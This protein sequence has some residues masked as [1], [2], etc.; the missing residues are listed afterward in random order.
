V[1]EQWQLKGD[2]FDVCKCTIPCPCTFAQ[3][4]SEGDC[5]GILAWH[6]NE[7]HYGDVSL[8]GLNIIGV[9]SF[10]GNIWDEETKATMGM[11]MDERADDA[12]REA[13]QIIFSGQA[14][15][16]PGEFAQS[17]GEVRGMEFA[18]I[19]FE[20][21][22]DLA[23]WRAEIPGKVE[24]RAEALTGPTTPEGARVQTHNPPGAEVGP[25][26]VATWGVATASKADAMGWSFDW[27]GRS[28]KHFPFDWSGP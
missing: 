6:I 14:G 27:A 9:G 23:W 10:D 22:D 8:D 26:Q 3:A 16:W 2:W 19:E 24:A 4:P 18:P 15:G 20:I 5:E 11:F 12:Q 21:A 13:L 1:A 28:S 25:G 7:G 17:V